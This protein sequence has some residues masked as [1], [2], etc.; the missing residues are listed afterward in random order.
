MFSSRISGTTKIFPA[1]PICYLHLP[2]AHTP[3]WL[4]IAYLRSA[5]H[6]MFVRPAKSNYRVFVSLFGN[7]AM[8]QQKALISCQ[9]WILPEG[10]LLMCIAFR[11]SGGD[12]HRRVCDLPHVI[13]LHSVS[14][15]PRKKTLQPVLLHLH[16]QLAKYCV[17]AL[18]IA[19]L[20]V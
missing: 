8:E 7:I 19:A 13:C 6:C 2:F 9:I 14:F 12:F 5:S 16:S 20:R 18:S 17:F 3:T 4:H 1:F 10:E 15:C 11:L